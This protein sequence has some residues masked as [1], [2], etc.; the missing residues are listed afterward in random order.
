M[1]DSRVVAM[2]RDRRPAWMLRK[3][4]RICNRRNE[5]FGPEPADAVTW[6]EQINA[7]AA[8]LALEAGKPEDWQPSPD[9][10]EPM[11]L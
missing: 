3:H 5:R 1:R 11:E 8:D 7:A 4:A 10:D 9:P 6:W 2:K